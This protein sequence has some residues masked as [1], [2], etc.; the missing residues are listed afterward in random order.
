M[1]IHQIHAVPNSPVIVSV[2][3]TGTDVPA[4][5]ERQLAVP[6]QQVQQRVDTFAWE[7]ARTAMP[8]ATVL[9]ALLGRAVVDLNRSGTVSALDLSH[10]PADDAQRLVQLFGQHG[11]LLWKAGLGGA[12][13]SCSE[14][15]ERVVLYHEPYHAALRQLLQQ[16]PRP[17]LLVDMH[18]ME[19]T[20]FDLVI[21]D[22]RGRSAGVELCES[23]I[24]PFFIDRGYRVGYAGPR[25]VDRRGRALSNV[26]IRH[27]GGFITSRFGDPA[28]GC[29]A[30]QIE[31]SRATARR[32]LATMEADFAAF[33]AHMQRVLCQRAAADQEKQD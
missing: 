6:L 26:A 1:Q 16:A 29:Y 28:A 11:K 30:V 27:S 22:F 31:T 33:F 12:A 20:A 32:R 7:L 3:H 10:D 13:L 2:P 24:R 9:R 23:V 5:V 14:L 25:G 8:Q 4:A 19:E 21:G 17:T 18:S 15:E